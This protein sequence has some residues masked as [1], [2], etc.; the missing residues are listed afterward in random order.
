MAKMAVNGFIESERRG[1][2]DPSKFLQ[3]S[4]AQ[5]F[6]KDKYLNEVTIAINKPELPDGTI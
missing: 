4:N 1:V 2:E 5:I 6:S 3:F